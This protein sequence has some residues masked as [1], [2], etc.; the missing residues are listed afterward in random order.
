MVELLEP[1]AAAADYRE[2]GRKHAV[3]KPRQRQLMLFVARLDI[4]LQQPLKAGNHLIRLRH[5]VLVR[6]ELVLIGKLENIL[7]RR[8]AR[9]DDFFCKIEIIELSRQ[10][11]Q[12]DKG[13]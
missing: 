6:A 1:A 4:I 2:I 7:D 3:G 11:I 5:G 13:L 8:A 10:P 9:V 12:L